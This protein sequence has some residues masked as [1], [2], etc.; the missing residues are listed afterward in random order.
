MWMMNKE[1]YWLFSL[2][3]IKYLIS[4]I[5]YKISVLNN[6]ILFHLYAAV[7]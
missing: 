6:I 3:T 2:T 7:K 5:I 4:L 1:L